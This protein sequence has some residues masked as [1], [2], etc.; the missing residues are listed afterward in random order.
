MI[1][2]M[3]QND[4]TP[5]KF[6]DAIRELQIG[7]LMRKSN[8][9]KS[10]G[11]S[12][13]DVL[14]FLLLL[15]FQGKNL[16][17]FLNSKHKDQAVSKNTY[18][19]FWNETSY[20]WSK[21]LLL[22]AT[23]VA[24]V[25][26]ALIRPERV[27]VLIW[28]D[29]V[30]KPN[31]IKSVELLARVFDHVEHKYQK[32]FTLLTLGWSDGYSFIPTGFN[33]L[34]SA[35]ESNRYNEISNQID[36]RTNGYKFRKESMMHKTDAAVL[37]VKDAL[38][39]GIKAD[40]VLMD[41][42]FT[43][44]PMIKEVLATGIDVIGM[45][46]QLKQR[47]AYNGKQY[48]LP[49]LKKFVC[50]DEGARNIFGSLVVTTKTGI[51]VKIVFVR[52]HNKKSEC[53]YIL[54]TNCS[55]ADEEIVRIYGNRWSIECFFKSSKSFMKL[56][57]EFQS[58]NYGAMVSHTV[59]VFTRYIILA[60]I[61]RNENDQKTYGELFFMF[62]EDIQDMELSNSLQ[63][64]MDLFVKHISTLSADITS[65]IKS[66]VT[67]WMLSQA[68]FI[69]ALLRNICWE[70]LVTKYIPLRQWAF[71]DSHSPEYQKFK[72]DK[73]PKIFNPKPVDYR[74]LL[75]YYTHKYIKT[76]K[77]VNRRSE[78]SKVNESTVRPRCGAPHKYIYK[79]NSSKGQYQ[80]KVCGELFNET[81]V[82]SNPLTLRCPYCGHILTP[83]KDRKHFRIHK[84]VNSKCSYYRKNLEKL[85][86]DLSYSDKHKYKL[87][88]IYREFTIDFFKTD[89]HGLP[90]RAINFKYQKFN[91]HI[92]ELALLITLILNYLLDSA[93]LTRI[94]S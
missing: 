87:H 62:C 21:F 64:L 14:Q 20:N 50:F 35:N 15:V 74:L 61:R 49:E 65:L 94:L 46:K 36:H 55:L 78:G 59:I 51:P 32:G 44:E 30:I 22:L 72:V 91:A 77:T 27:K 17:R 83:K 39:A 18:Y 29:S 57:T 9:T 81:N 89:L 73:L 2:Q 8:I 6:S 11:I 3:N 85:P 60:W 76:V 41:T 70:S 45:V 92:M 68:P 88:Y 63:S 34:S 69:Q 1:N 25:F 47:Y 43:T 56:G 12:A 16:F 24:T 31:R 52:N 54:S 90:S 38:N 4:H 84:C 66:K 23:K 80:C 79:N 42:W 53:L 48:T 75:A 7:K 93:C 13:Y 10:C 19:R 37:L 67:E 26:D 71:E 33:M 86:K 82:Y 58:H 5:N 40:Y 28:D